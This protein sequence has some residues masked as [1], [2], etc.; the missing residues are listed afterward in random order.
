[1]SE[2][3]AFRAYLEKNVPKRPLRPGELLQANGIYTAIELDERFGKP[4]D[5]LIVPIASFE[6]HQFATD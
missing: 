2:S 3:D 5:R 4:D 6:G 1:M